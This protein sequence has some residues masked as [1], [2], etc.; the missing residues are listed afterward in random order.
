VSSNLAIPTLENKA[1]I[2]MQMGAFFVKCGKSVAFFLTLAA[3][4]L[5]KKYQLRPLYALFFCLLNVEQI[6]IRKG[7]FE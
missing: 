7:H 4:A 6:N 5:V 3:R 2:K 1:L